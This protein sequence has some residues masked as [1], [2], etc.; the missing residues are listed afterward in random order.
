MEIVVGLLIYCFSWF[1]ER[2]VRS[3][4]KLAASDLLTGATRGQGRWLQSF[5]SAPPTILIVAAPSFFLFKMTVKCFFCSFFCN[6]L[7]RYSLSHNRWCKLLWSCPRLGLPL[8]CKIRHR[9]TEQ[10]QIIGLLQ[11]PSDLILLCLLIKIYKKS[12]IIQILIILG[13]KKVLQ[14]KLTGLYII[15]TIP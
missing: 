15:W 11:E 9:Q 5:N 8:I 7:K 1:L 13:K 6:L 10:D 14:N 3:H 12:K 2:C 4:R